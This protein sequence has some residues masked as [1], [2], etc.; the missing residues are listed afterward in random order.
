MA[1]VNSGA[2]IGRWLRG[3]TDPP[4]Q[5]RRPHPPDDITRIEHVG[6]RP[7]HKENR[8]AV[9][10]AKPLV[11]YR[12]MRHYARAGD[13]RVRPLDY[14]ITL[15]SDPIRVPFLRSPPGGLARAIDLWAWKSADDPQPVGP[16]NCVGSLQE[17]VW[18]LGRLPWAERAAA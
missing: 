17:G 4:P 2:W 3:A 18:S 9:S 8:P 13:V 7:H 15:T 11:D 10:L 12:H 5:K 14:A 1:V 16:N 6:H